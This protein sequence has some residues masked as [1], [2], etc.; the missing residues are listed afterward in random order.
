MFFLSSPLI[1]FGGQLRMPLERRKRSQKQQPRRRLQIE[2]QSRALS[3][4]MSAAEAATSGS[5]AI[6]S[7]R[8]LAL[9]LAGGISSPPFPP[10]FAFQP[11]STSLPACSSHHC[12]VTS[13][14]RPPATGATS[15]YIASFL[16]DPL[17]AVLPSW[18]HRHATAQ[19]IDAC[20]NVRSSLGP[21]EQLLLLQAQFECGFGE[22]ALEELR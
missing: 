18:R 3:A 16:F 17:Q 5:V 15:V 1:S 9:F 6:C 20:A 22:Q 7:D 11:N 4:A 21:E 8:F 14:F 2:T 10:P 19:V 12:N 13:T